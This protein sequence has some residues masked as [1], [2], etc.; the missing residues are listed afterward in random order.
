MDEPA[1]RSTCPPALEH[2]VGRPSSVGSLVRPL[3]SLVLRSFAAAKL[4]RLPGPGESRSPY[5]RAPKRCSV[6]RLR[7]SALGQ[8]RRRHP[9]ACGPARAAR[10][11]VHRRLRT[12]TSRS[13]GHGGL[14]VVLVNPWRVRRFGEGLGQLAKNDTIDARLLAHFATVVELEPTTVRRGR[15]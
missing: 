1:G 14:P 5:P 8:S 6:F 4:E 7:A 9:G 10:A 3:A 12:A 11:R 15:E 13:L 2:G